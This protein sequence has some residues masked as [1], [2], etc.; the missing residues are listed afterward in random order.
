MKYK[1]ICDKYGTTFTFVA[2]GRFATV[3]T[4]IKHGSEDRFKH[5][6]IDP[7]T[8]LFVTFKDD[9]AIMEEEIKER[10]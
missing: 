6:I 9:D 2:D 7:I 1:E 3:Y 5:D 8:G 4:V 10:T